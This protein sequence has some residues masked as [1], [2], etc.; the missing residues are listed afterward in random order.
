M[1]ATGSDA[2]ARV[3]ACFA[4]KS[5]L[6]HAL[7]VGHGEDWVA[8]F[9]AP[10]E[11]ER[12]P[13]LP[14]LAGSIPLYRVVSGWWFPVGTRLDVPDHARA[15]ILAELLD[16]HDFGLPAIVIPRMGLDGRGREADIYCCGNPV[17][18]SDSELA[19]P[20]DRA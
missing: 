5:A 12:D 18:F 3:A 7:P 16:R 2:R 13:V 19:A 11:G 4:E 17:P 1:L 10:L 14:R 8:I 9:A 20:E 15:A 6:F